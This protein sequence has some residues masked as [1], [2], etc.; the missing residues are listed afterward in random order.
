MGKIL[1]S[2]WEV[3]SIFNENKMLAT[4]LYHGG[5]GTWEK[6]MDYPGEKEM[7]MYLENMMSGFSP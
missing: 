5:S 6:M 4:I 2:S 3:L 7:G 1:K